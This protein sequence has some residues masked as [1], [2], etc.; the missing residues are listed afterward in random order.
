[1]GVDGELYVEGEGDL[2]DNGD[3]TWELHIPVSLT[4]GTY[5]VVAHSQS[6]TSTSTRVDTSTDEL[7]VD[8][9]APVSTISLNLTPANGNLSVADLFAMTVLSGNVE[10]EFIVGDTVTLIINDSVYTA[11]VDSE[12]NFSV[13]VPRFQLQSN[14]TI[15]ASI[16]TQDAFGNIGLSTCLL[17][18]SP[19]PRDATLSRMPSSA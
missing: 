15:A 16:S 2:I 3:N 8:A 1:M 5:D 9:T 18:T 11:I 4:D 19:S 7:V 14:A 10:G 17:Y 12:G 6:L 13:E